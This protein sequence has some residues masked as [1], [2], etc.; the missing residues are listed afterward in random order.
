M[1]AQQRLDGEHDDEDRDREDPEQLSKLRNARDGVPRSDYPP[2]VVAKGEW[3][4]HADAGEY[5][6]VDCASPHT[7]QRV[8]TAD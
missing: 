3:N 8:P 2:Q 6:R 1:E 5:T 7:V 4:E